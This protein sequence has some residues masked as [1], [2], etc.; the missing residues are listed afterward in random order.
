MKNTV[1]RINLEGELGEK[2]GKVWN[3]NVSSPAEAIRAIDVQR[4]GFRKHFLDTHNAGMGYDIIIG[5]QGI[6][7]AEEIGFP[8]PIRDDFTFIPIPA[9]SKQQQSGGFYFVAGL[10]LFA[11]SGGFSALGSMGAEATFASQFGAANMGL[12]GGGGSYFFAMAGAALMAGGVSMMLAPSITEDDT[13]E[14]QSYLF[15]GPVNT[16][17]QGVPVPILYGRMIVGGATVS[18]SV[19][20]DAT[21]GFGINVARTIGGP[22]DPRKDPV[23]PTNPGTPV[24]GGCFI[25]GTL[26][27]MADGTEKEISLIELNDYTRGGRVESLMQFLPSI[28][29]DYKG[30]K[31]SS[32]HWVKEEGQFIKIENSKYGILTDQIAPV[33]CLVTSEHRIF[34]NDIEFTDYTVIGS[35]KEAGIEDVVLAIINKE[36]NKEIRI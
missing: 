11:A 18:A 23:D 17:K 25:K 19:S 20:S 6:K 3:L 24:V 1:R 22:H 34:I 28:I 27:Q 10:L 5:D 35:W 4:K 9:G 21:A 2:F 14:E 29:Y 36:S 32:T 16:A 13:N 7:Q 31:V 26:V 8:A 12:F 30:V 15:D 33:Y